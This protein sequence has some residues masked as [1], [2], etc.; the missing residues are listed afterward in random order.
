MTPKGVGLLSSPPRD[1]IGITRA[2]R[3]RKARIDPSKFA[4]IRST[5]HAR[6]FP[7]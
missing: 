7:R 5:G 2:G 6:L 4:L 3:L 1:R